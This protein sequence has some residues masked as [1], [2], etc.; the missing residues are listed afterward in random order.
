MQDEFKDKVAC[1]A[2]SLDHDGSTPVEE[3]RAK[4][5]AKLAEVGLVITCDNVVCANTYDEAQKHYDFAFVP[6]VAVYDREGKQHELEDFDYH[7]TITPLVKQ[8]LAE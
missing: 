4:V 7:E 3:D 5:V 2:L 1:I 6:F 8:L